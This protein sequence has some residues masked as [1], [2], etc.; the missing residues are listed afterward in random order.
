MGHNV[1][2]ICA[3][4]TYFAHENRTLKHLTSVGIELSKKEE[5]INLFIVNI[6]DLFPIPTR[7]SNLLFVIINN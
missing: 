7:N 4:V 5:E 1:I 2:N 6:K 3:H